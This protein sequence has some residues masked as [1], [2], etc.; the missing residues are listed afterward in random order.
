[1]FLNIWPVDTRR[2]VDARLLLHSELHMYTVG[3]DCVWASRWLYKLDFIRFSWLHME[4]FDRSQA[5]HY[6]CPTSRSPLLKQT[7]I[8]QPAVP[9]RLPQTPLNQRRCI[10]LHVLSVGVD[11]MCNKHLD[12]PNTKTSMEILNLVYAI[13]ASIHV[14]IRWRSH[15]FTWSEP[16]V[17]VGQ[18]LCTIMRSFPLP[19][20]S[21]ARE[22]TQ[23][24]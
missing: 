24:S 16:P 7:H 5:F 4:S 17:Y 14:Q 2:C 3:L 21:T 20:F 23:F 12:H 1:M 9:F 15:L 18:W 13:I 6:L 11:C 8:I 19:L 10:H 22:M